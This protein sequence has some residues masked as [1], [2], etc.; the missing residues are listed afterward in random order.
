MRVGRRV[1]G[2]AI[3]VM[4]LVGVS[5]PF[6][7]SSRPCKSFQHSQAVAEEEMMVAQS[8]LQEWN[9]K[10]GGFVEESAREVPTGPD[11]LHHNNKPTRP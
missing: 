5:P 11:P 7:L 8:Q 9:R 4:F 3:L 6:V 1:T 10:E 2:F